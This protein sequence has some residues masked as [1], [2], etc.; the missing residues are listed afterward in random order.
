[1]SAYDIKY[2][3]INKKYVTSSDTVFIDSEN[4]EVVCL[5]DSTKLQKWSYDL[6]LEVLYDLKPLSKYVLVN[7]D[8]KRPIHDQFESAKDLSS[9]F[10]DCA[11]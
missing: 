5:R 10:S 1:V 2:N 11:S 3:F 4:Y 7:Y 6:Y 8:T 9:R